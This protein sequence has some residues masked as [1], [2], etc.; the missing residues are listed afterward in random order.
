MK[1]MKRLVWTGVVAFL[2]GIF[3]ALIIGEE[4]FSTYGFF[5][6]YNL[7]SF[8][9]CEMDQV[10]LFWNIVWQRGKMMILVFLLSSTVLSKFMPYALM[11]LGGF[12]FG[13]L[14]VVCA[15]QM[16][17]FGIIVPACSWIPHGGFYLIVLMILIRGRNLIRF[18]NRRKKLYFFLLGF[19]LICLFFVGCFLETTLGTWVMQN[20]F[21]LKY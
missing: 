13:I 16:G 15:M 3:T 7:K 18:E 14:E 6:E 12:S 20:I 21:Q 2:A 4:F 19:G 10:S 5:S 9:Y 17:I 8:A 1:N 11:A